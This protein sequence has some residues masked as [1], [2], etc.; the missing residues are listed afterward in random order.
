MALAITIVL[1]LLFF[2]FIAAFVAMSDKATRHRREKQ[3]KEWEAEEQRL[4]E[5]KFKVVKRSGQPA[6]TWEVVTDVEYDGVWVSF[7][8]CHGRLTT[9]SG[10]VIVTE[11]LEETEPC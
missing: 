5:K 9:V 3:Q 1:L 10:S 11:I 7:R 6:A 4:R 2:A 8:D